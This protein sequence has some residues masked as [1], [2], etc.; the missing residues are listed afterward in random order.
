MRVTVIGCWGGSPRPGGACSGYLLEYDGRCILLDCGAGVAS[1]VQGVRP[2]ERIDDVFVSHFHHDHVSDAGVMSYARLVHRQLGVTDRPLTFY[3]PG[4]DERGMGARDLAMRGASRSVEVGEGSR[5]DV[6]PFHL[7]FMR[8]RHPR[9]CLATRVSCDDGT[10]LGYTADGALTPE[11]VRF[12]G[13]VDV[14]V[15]ECSLYAGYDGASFGHMSCEDVAAL[16]RGALPGTLVLSHLPI[17]GEV[18]G[19][20][21]EVGA[22]LRDLPVRVVLAEDGAGLGRTCVDAGVA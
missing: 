7:Q 4:R 8:T 15:S 18:K 12:L 6:G 19:L 13:G 16:G 5:L 21:S 11:L 17:Y 3:A 10:T 22:A 2:L 20:L 1:A 14:L 9:L